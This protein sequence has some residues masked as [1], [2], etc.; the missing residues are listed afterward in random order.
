[1]NKDGFDFKV[2]SHCKKCFKIAKCDLAKSFVSDV[3]LTKE[4][5]TVEK[6]L[7]F[8]PIFKQKMEE[9]KAKLVLD[10]IKG[11]DTPKGVYFKHG[12]RFKYWMDEYELKEKY[13]DKI[14]T[15][16]TMS[17]AQAMREKVDTKEELEKLYAFTEPKIIPTTTKPKKEVERTTY[18]DL[19]DEELKKLT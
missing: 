5:P 10:F 7:L 18:K 16:K 3:V 8:E 2:G 12:N 1:M 15:K 9:V 11:R 13:G 6:L 4:T 19:M 17:P 14:V